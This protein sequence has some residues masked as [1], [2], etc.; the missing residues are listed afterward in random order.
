MGFYSMQAGSPVS[1]LKPAIPALALVTL[2]PL[3][4][5]LMRF[6][7]NRNFAAEMPLIVAASLA[8]AQFSA[9]IQRNTAHS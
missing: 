2:T 1:E 7:I 4:L 5:V 6:G 9:R 3:A 8:A